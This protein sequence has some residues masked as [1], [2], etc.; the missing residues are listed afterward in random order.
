MLISLFSARKAAARAVGVGVLSGAMLF[1]A[2]P[3][4]QA[5]EVAAP[6][7]SVA[8]ADS[9]NGA[10][11]V[12]DASRAD[13]NNRADFGRVVPMDDDWWDPDD[14]WGPWWPGWHGGPWWH[15]GPGWHGG[16][17]GGPGWHGGHGRH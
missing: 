12:P 17:H 2:A 5:V 1:G 16:W 13:L 3:V 15:G 11:G 7:P 10:P 14:W 6:T 9:P 4:A 8:G